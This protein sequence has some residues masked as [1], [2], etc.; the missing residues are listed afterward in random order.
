MLID[1]AALT[2]FSWLVAKALNM[3]FFK[4]A[5]ASNFVTWTLTFGYFICGVILASVVKFF[6]DAAIGK[7][8]G[9][10]MSAHNP[11]D[12]ATAFIMALVFYQVLNRALKKSANSRVQ[13]N[14]ANPDLPKRAPAV[15]SMP[16]ATSTQYAVTPPH[17]PTGQPA[18]AA[19]PSSL[20]GS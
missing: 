19:M 12:M 6:R 15:S 9:I 3:V 10:S 20:P 17:A 8:L 5:P 14:F 11:I 13:A 4:G 7:S 16:A 18:R 1:M 2:A